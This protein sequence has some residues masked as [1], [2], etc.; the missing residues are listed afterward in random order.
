MRLSVGQEKRK[1]EDKRKEARVKKKV[2]QIWLVLINRNGN[3]SFVELI[4]LY[5]VK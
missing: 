1:T 2:L 3:K 4:I 5:I